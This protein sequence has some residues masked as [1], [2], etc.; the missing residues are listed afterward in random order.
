MFLQVVSAHVKGT[1]TCLDEGGGLV[2]AHVF[3]VLVPI[4]CELALDVRLELHQPLSDAFDLFTGLEPSKDSL[5]VD[6]E[7]LLGMN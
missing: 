7:V 4:A 5:D 6:A 1:P 3:C 2:P